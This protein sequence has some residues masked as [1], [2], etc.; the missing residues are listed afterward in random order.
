MGTRLAPRPVVLGLAV[1]GLCGLLAPRVEAATCT[2]GSS[3]ETSVQGYIDETTAGVLASACVADDQVWTAVS[4][5][6]EVR[7]V[8]E[9]AGYA[10]KNEFGIYDPTDSSQMLR[11][12]AGADAAFSQKTLTV[13]PSSA[14]VSLPR[15]DSR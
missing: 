6:A 12:F 3:G 7:L 15:A 1:A 8:F 11:V 13:S 10:M 9:F 14:S 5:P 4:S 2:Y